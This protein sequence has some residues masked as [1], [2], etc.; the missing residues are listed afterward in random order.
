MTRRPWYRWVVLA[1][2][3][4]GVFGALGF[5]R[6]GYS[7]VLPSMQ[8][9]LGISSAA[10]G[11]LA[12]WNLAGYTLMA[13]VGGVLAT[14]L[15]ARRVITAGVA[16]TAAGM[17][18]TGI[19]GG[20]AGASAGRF[21]TG[22]GNGMVLVPSVTLMAAWFDQRRLGLASSIVT[23]GSSLALVLVGLVVP[24]VISG[25]GGGGWRWAWYFFAAVTVAIALLGAVFLR[26]RP[27]NA[28]TRRWEIVLPKSA[29]VALR[30]RMPKPSLELKKIVRSRYAWH[31]GVV[32]MLYGVGFLIYFTFFQKR[33]TTDLGYSG[34]IAGYLFLVVGVAGLFGGVLWGSVS[35]HVGRRTSIALAL[36][37]GAVASFLF[38]FR[39][40][41]ASLVVSAVLF[42]STGPVLPGLVSAACSE[43]FGYRLASASLGFITILVG[44]GQTIGPY[45]GGVMGDEFGSLSPTYYFSAALFA[46][47]AL[48]VLM[49][50]DTGQRTRSGTVE[51]LPALPARRGPMR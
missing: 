21:L 2:A 45:L 11:S 14:R 10:A 41:L 22:V 50:G 19:S 34:E 29:P 36:A 43:K 31:L 18:F 9:A 15:G 38:G 24:R 1:A 39:P 32:Y 12:S 3:F 51:R 6:F 46:A 30:S 16:V 8:E 49:L 7:A 25:A 35:D 33:L 26:D 27:H 47:G 44:L 17:F 20:L 13:A 4:W 23:T 5:G 28:P 48:S 37:L 40:H 42:G